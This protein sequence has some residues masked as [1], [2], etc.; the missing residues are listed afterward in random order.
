MAHVLGLRHLF[1][2]RSPANTVARLLN[3]GDAPAGVDGVFHPPYVETHLGVAEILRR[4]RLLLL[5]GRGGEA[6]GT[7]LKPGS[8][9]LWDRDVG[10]TEIALP[11]RQ[12]LQSPTPASDTPELLTAVWRGETSPPTQVATVVAT[13]ALG[14][15]SL[16]WAETAAS[17]ES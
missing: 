4:E 2:L 17:A 15:L 6:E 10:R 16:G 9:W 1:G 3:P 5:K 12:G 11:G 8:G 14:V 7:P 13:I